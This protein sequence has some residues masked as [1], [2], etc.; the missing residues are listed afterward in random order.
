MSIFRLYVKGPL[1]TLKIRWQSHSPAREV[2]IL[3]GPEMPRDSLSNN[4]HLYD[5][6]DKRIEKETVPFET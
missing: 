4:I 5:Q 6:L 1:L 3:T 2:W